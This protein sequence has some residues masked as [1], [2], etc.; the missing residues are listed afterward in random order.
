MIT[1]YVYNTE[2][3]DDDFLPNSAITI[4]EF[5]ESTPLW[6]PR[7]DKMILVFS[8]IPLTV[9]EDFN[10]FGILSHILP[11]L[12]ELK[13]RLSNGE[14]G[15]LRTCIQGEAL[16]FIFEPK[17]EITL[18]SSLGVFPSP[19]NNY[20]PLLD[21]PNYFKD[22]NQ[23]D[24][25]YNFVRSNNTGNWKDSLIGNNPKIQKIEYETSK[26]IESIDEQIKLANQLISL[27]K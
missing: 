18:F 24:D 7:L 26:L 15:L 2:D 9:N 6:K 19:F 13:L 23:Q 11:Q 10:N 17:E 27:M 5:L 16:F 8:G 4:D 14:F 25:L 3:D 12:E 21:S 22:V 20:Y 1:F